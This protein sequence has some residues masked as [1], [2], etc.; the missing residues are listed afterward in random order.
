M[1]AFLSLL[2][3]SLI[4]A[5]ALLAQQQDTR[6][7]QGPRNFTMPADAAI[8]SAATLG[9][10]TLVV[11]GTTTFAGDSSVI[12]QLRMQM[13]R[14][15]MADGEQRS[16]HGPDARPFGA[17]SVIGLQ[18]AFLVLWN[19]RRPGAP[20]IYMR[21]VDASG[22]FLGGEEYFAEGS[23]KSDASV[24][25]A[26]ITS[27]GL[28]FWTNVRDSSI[29][30][31][32]RKVSPSG[33]LLGGI[34]ILSPGELERVVSL[35][36]PGFTVVYR[37]RHPP[38]IFDLN[39]DTLTDARWIDHLSH[40]CYVNAD[41]SVVEIQDTLLVCYR[42]VSDS[43][44][45][46][47][48]SI[49]ATGRPFPGDNGTLISNLPGSI[50]S[51]DSA[52]NYEVVWTQLFLYY[53]IEWNL[54]I[55]RMRVYPIADSVPT[56][57]DRFS[58][59]DYGGPGAILGVG[60]TVNRQQRL[61]GNTVRT[62]ITVGWTYHLPNNGDH[63]DQRSVAFIV[64]ENGEYRG[65][66]TPPS[67]RVS[68]GS[69][70]EYPLLQRTSADSV[71]RV[72]AT[73]GTASV[74]LS[75]TTAYLGN[76]FPQ[77]QPELGLVK[78]S[79]EASFREIRNTAT[80]VLGRLDYSGSTPV[81]SLGSPSLPGNVTALLG[82]EQLHLPGILAAR[83]LARNS[84]YYPGHDPIWASLY[85]SI[86]YVA[87]EQGWRQTQFRMADGGGHGYPPE[88]SHFVYAPTGYDPNT[89]TIV[90]GISMT[91][92]AATDF[93]GLAAGG[94]SLWS[95]SFLSPDYLD[96]MIVPVSPGTLLLASGSRVRQVAGGTITH[97]WNLPLHGSPR[98]VRYYRTYGPS[99]LRVEYP[100]GADSSLLLE[101]YSL[102]CQRMSAQQVS[103][104]ELL[105]E[106]RLVL[107]PED[108]SVAVLAS[109]RNGLFLEYLDA[110]LNVQRPLSGTGDLARVSLS[111]STDSIRS[112]TG[113]FRGDTLWVAWEDHR[114]GNP[115]MY[116]NWWVVPKTFR[117][118][119][120]NGDTVWPPDTT[121]AHDSTDALI[122]GNGDVAI[123]GL[124]PNPIHS[125]ITV[126]FTTRTQGEVSMEI[127]DMLGRRIGQIA[128]GTLHSGRYQWGMNCSGLAPGAYL[129]IMRSA[130]GSDQRRVIV[131]PY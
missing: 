78:G 63:A 5:P 74:T 49:G 54:Y 105:T 101:K 118:H 57:L 87:T 13:L 38:V 79:I 97:T 115:D 90:A 21:R 23:L 68:C 32:Y 52:G 131:E 116:G 86:L 45:L 100:A 84:S 24:F 109:T 16:L 36:S 55:R 121:V 80:V 66:R 51:R 3:L 44:P 42:H 56:W 73:I 125:Y 47:T 128:G 111:R 69:E 58:G 8:Q 104:P 102:D 72:V 65:T 122:T 25:L 71:S 39:G 26:P 9:R 93:T 120:T 43:I 59:G 28:L 88:D 114:N 92:G 2:V 6:L 127:V 11:F 70:A 27:G 19:D 77:L 83:A 107:R 81:T 61:C 110:N 76:A 103:L 94:D 119:G 89:S 62:D 95:I 46:W 129:V 98:F 4:A 112:G 48:A 15:S 20:G 7:S 117:S 40:A 37:V 10:R 82:L 126:K 50:V 67:G 124:Y 17:V 14:D 91:A 1:I 123:T 31:H 130:L 12:N 41:S 53:P 64:T 96:T 34:E 99:F 22:A 75:A 106:P 30:I 85:Y 113:A 60:A 33:M 108:S 35:E 29:E 18:G